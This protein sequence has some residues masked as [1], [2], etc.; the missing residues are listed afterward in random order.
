MGYFTDPSSGDK[1]PSRLCSFL[2]TC[3]AVL[4]AFY[5]V[6]KGHPGEGVTLM[7]AVLGFSWGVYG[8]NSATRVVMTRGITPIRELPS[9]P[10]I[11]PEGNGSVG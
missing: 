10:E 4:L 3:A 6:S 1:S 7:V 8:A 9:R 5:L 11:K 2:S